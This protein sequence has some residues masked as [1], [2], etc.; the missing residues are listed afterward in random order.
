MAIDRKER[1]K[2]YVSN[3]KTYKYGDLNPAT[4]PQT[5]RT[6][7]PERND[8]ITNLRE[9]ARRVMEPNYL[10]NL[11]SPLRAICLG[12]IFQVPPQNL[13]QDLGIKI[14]GFA[15]QFTVIARIPEF[16]AHLPD[17][18]NAEENKGVWYEVYPEFLPQSSDL[19][20]PK[21][22]DIISVDFGNRQTQADPRYFGIFA[23]ADG[24][25]QNA[26]S[27]T[28]KETKLNSKAP[29][30]DS[31]GSGQKILLSQA[32]TVG[33]DGIPESIRKVSQDS[34]TPAHR[35]V[36]YK[37]G[38]I[39]GE[40]GLVTFTNPIRNSAGQLEVTIVA[41][42]RNDM[43]AMSKAMFEGDSSRGVPG[44]KHKIVVNSGFRTNEKQDQ[45]YRDYTSG[46]SKIIAA[47][48]GKS[49]HQRGN[50]ADISVVSPKGERLTLSATTAPEAWRWL[51]KYAI[52]FNFEW[53]EGARLRRPEP[54]HWNYSKKISYLPVEGTTTDA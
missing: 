10:D 48:P 22:G 54:H 37:N 12:V 13:L 41:D 20:P 4:H 11:P 45:L 47:P 38:N 33:D 9:A 53:T 18:R 27:K 5:G 46:R 25:S 42:M 21:V 52:K 8:G 1:L 28:T 49:L 51:Q 36:A 31:I 39:I 35:G 43:E 23:H 29:T 3:E 6:L 7:D 15:P 14:Q 24:A 19:E 16:H 40:V 44:I 26:E 17:P 50:A 2:R 34:G 32:P 30:G